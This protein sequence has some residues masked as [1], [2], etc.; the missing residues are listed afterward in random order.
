MNVPLND[1]EVDRFLRIF[2]AALKNQQSG[3]MNVF[4]DVTFA[5][6]K[7]HAAK[8]AEQKAANAPNLAVMP[9][10]SESAS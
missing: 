4:A 5:F 2:D 9:S 6:N 8:V 7:L 1:Q 3:G 10:V